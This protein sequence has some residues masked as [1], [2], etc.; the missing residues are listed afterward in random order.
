MI[1]RIY[2]DS[3][4]SNLPEVGRIC[5]RF[6]T[7]IEI[8]PGPKAVY[9]SILDAEDP[10]AAGKKALFITRNRGEFIRDCPGTRHY[11][12]C[13]YKILHIGTYCPMDCSYCILQTY[14]HPPVLQY[15]VNEGDL[16]DSL[17]DVFRCERICRIGTGEFTDSLIWEPWTQTTRRL[18]PA[19]AVQ[20]RSVLELKTKTV[21]IDPLSEVVHNRKTIT[22]WS[23]NTERIIGSEERN[24]ASLS[25]R[26]DAAM[27]SES[28]G[29][30]LAFHFDPMIL[31][32]GCIEEYLRVVD[33][34]FSSVS[35]E[36]V[37]W[38]SLGTFRFMPALKPIIQTRFPD[39]KIVYGEFIPG[40]DGKMRYFKPLRIELYRKMIERIRAYGA[41]VTVYLCMEDGEAWKKSMGYLPAERGGLPAMLD[42]RARRICGLKTR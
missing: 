8:V 10:I 40:L 27:R 4:V 12:C 38:I 31:Y 34:I 13:M 17:E 19:F 11:T 3:E 20:N 22:S 14:F 18:V 29:Y 1:R 30:P 9:R 33:R 37:A 23:M 5:S 21:N 15:F 25:Q 32:D 36:N 26:L 35:A 2:I 6:D 39:S 24:T 42:E 41:E 28:W 16:F 7:P